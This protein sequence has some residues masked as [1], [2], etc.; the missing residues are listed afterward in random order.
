MAVNSWAMGYLLLTKPP[1]ARRVR[2]FDCAAC[3]VFLTDG[4]PGNVWS[5]AGVCS[6]IS[7]ATAVATAFSAASSRAVFSLPC[8]ERSAR[9]AMILSYLGLSSA[10]A[11]SL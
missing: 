2:F 4:R 10:K 6:F 11:A 1:P 3:P 7:V 5:G 8:S 9:A